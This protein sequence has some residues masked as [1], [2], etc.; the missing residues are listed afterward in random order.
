MTTDDVIHAA[1]YHLDPRQEYI[2]RYW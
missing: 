1:S 2:N